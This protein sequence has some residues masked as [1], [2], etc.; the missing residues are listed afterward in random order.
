MGKRKVWLGSVRHDFV[1]FPNQTGTA[2]SSPALNQPSQSDKLS[3]L[4]KMVIPNIMI[5]MMKNAYEQTTI[6]KVAK[7][8]RHLERN[9]DTN[10]PEGVKLYIA[11]KQCS[12]GHKQNL[13]EAYACFIKSVGAKWQQPFYPRYSNKTQRR[14]YEKRIVK[15]TLL[16]SL[17][18]SCSPTSINTE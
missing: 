14:E 6:K 2:T 5:W 8:L 11:K 13:I 10:S 4:E 17:R 9:C 18:N 1:I 12:N 15:S 7:L 16:D 3:H